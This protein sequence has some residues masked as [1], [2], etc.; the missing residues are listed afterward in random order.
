MKLGPAAIAINGAVGG[1]VRKNRARQNVNSL[2]SLARDMAPIFA[3]A[4]LNERAETTVSRS[5]GVLSAS[6]ISAGISNG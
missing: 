4:L 6:R 5:S 1:V 3:A 2:F